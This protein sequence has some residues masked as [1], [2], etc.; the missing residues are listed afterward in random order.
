MRAS[1]GLLF[2]SA[3]TKPK[4]T[5]RRI[6]IDSR[7]EIDRQT[8]AR[9]GLAAYRSVAVRRIM[10]FPAIIVHLVILACCGCFRTETPL[11]TARKPSAKTV[12][13]ETSST[14]EAST[15]KPTTQKASA[16][17]VATPEAN[18]AA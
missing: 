7:P 2:S 4:L 15:N 9:C 11:P 16:E 14:Q 8:T 3:W 5:V 18:D 17:T 10:R 13:A 12:G 6:R 1:P